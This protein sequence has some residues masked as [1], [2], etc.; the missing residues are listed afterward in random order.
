[1]AYEQGPTISQETLPYLDSFTNTAQAGYA[2]DMA[3]LKRSALRE[4]DAEIAGGDQQGR[5]AGFQRKATE[6]G[7]MDEE[8]RFKSGLNLERAQLGEQLRGRD[9]QR[10]W[11][12]QDRDTRL[13]RLRAKALAERTR[14]EDEARGGLMGEIA[15]GAGTII[16]G[17]VG[18]Y[19]GGPTG[20]MVGAGAGGAVGG[21]VGAAL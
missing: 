10:A 4:L 13:A 3:G 14:A 1:M 12:V 16:G 19:Y 17:L 18:A 21:A 9:Q 8:D 6:Q 7:F 11:Q 5:I 20:A 2:D 15:G